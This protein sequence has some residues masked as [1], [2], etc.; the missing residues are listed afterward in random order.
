M[1]KNTPSIL[2]RAKRSKGA[3][4]SKLSLPTE[5]ENMV[6]DNF[7][8]LHKPKDLTWLWV[9]GRHVSKRFRYEI[10]RIFRKVFLP[11]TI[12]RCYLGKFLCDGAHVSIQHGGQSRDSTN[13]ITG[14]HYM[15]WDVFTPDFQAYAGCHLGMSTV[16]GY[17]HEPP[18]FT[19]DRFS[20]DHARAIFKCADYKAPQEIVFRRLHEKQ[21]VGAPVFSIQ[22]RK[23]VNDTGLPS[24]QIN[25]E[26]EEISI[27]W[28]GMLDQ[29][30]GEEHVFNTIFTQR[31]GWHLNYRHDT[32]NLLEA[33]RK[34]ARRSR[35]Q[36]ECR[37]TFGSNILDHYVHDEKLA[38]KSLQKLRLTVSG[39][40]STHHDDGDDK[41]RA[42][43]ASYTK[44]NIL[45]DLPDN[46]TIYSGDSNPRPKPGS[47]PRGILTDQ[48]YCSL[49]NQW[50][51]LPPASTVDL[52][53]PRPLPRLSWGRLPIKQNTKLEHDSSHAKRAREDDPAMS[54]TKRRKLDSD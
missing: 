11:E 19:L 13:I 42:Y 3:R 9:G 37:A 22:V 15:C 43:L 2:V 32:V 1:L 5:L 39:S 29:L 18:C 53:S 34:L 7:Q 48:D 24:L 35:L 6:L 50:R 31:L 40:K 41:K 52:F 10:E 12:L 46:A 38:L 21:L 17:N 25:D 36:R 27:D 23:V 8:Y 16:R 20:D 14:F 47:I 30:M 4:T 54:P 51:G 33:H 26:N 49:E 45:D 44:Q 28:R